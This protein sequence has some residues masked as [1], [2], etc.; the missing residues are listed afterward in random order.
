MARKGRVDAKVGNDSASVKPFSH[1]FRLFGGII[2]F[3]AGW[4]FSNAMLHCG[5]TASD[6]TL[7]PGPDVP[8][9]NYL[10]AA[11]VLLIGSSFALWLVAHP[12]LENLSRKPGYDVPDPDLQAPAVKLV[13]VAIGLVLAALH[14]KVCLVERVEVAGNSMYP[15][16][17]SGEVIWIQKLTTGLQLPDLSFPL[18]GISATGKVP[19]FGWGQPARGD[20]VVFRYPGVSEDRNDYYI[21]RVIGLP[22]D[23]YEIAGGR[24]YINGNE[25]PEPYLP[26]STR[27]RARPRYEQPAVYPLPLELNL[28]PPDVR[29]SALFGAGRRGSI[30]DNTLLVM[31]D[32]R[33]LSRD[34]R[35]IG[36]IPG[37]F[38]LGVA[39]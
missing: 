37:F 29:Q 20:V 18:G 24:V 1:G 28:L 8:L 26:A 4:F 6:L 39:F 36:F 7:P 13:V 16:L 3:Y 30:P 27:T 31:G 11:S 33:E 14:V 35:S 32:N 34:S 9:W 2:L 19:A 12:L 23:T 25:L 10:L 15:T 38:V 21:K 22:G 17:Q 5:S